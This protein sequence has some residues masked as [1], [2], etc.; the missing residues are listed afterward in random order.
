MGDLPDVY[1]YTIDDLSEIIR[2]NLEQREQA[3][4]AAEDLVRA[5]AERFLREQRTQHQQE[6]LRL[7]RHRAD[8][9]RDDE[10]QKALAELQRG[11]D[12]EAA[13]AQLARNLTNKLMHN[14]TVALRNAAAD[15][16]TDLVDYLK[17]LY[18]LD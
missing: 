16:R 17:S 9:W 18:Q 4:A 12:P 8:S 13:L 7:L 3:A 15:G 2:Q 1:L 5:G 11:A 14:Q 10:L 6:T